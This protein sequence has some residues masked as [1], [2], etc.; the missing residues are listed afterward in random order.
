MHDKVIQQNNEYLQKDFG[1]GYK[2]QP[3]CYRKHLETFGVF[4]FFSLAFYYYFVCV[5]KNYIPVD[6]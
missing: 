1:E 6:L 2:P 3:F 5:K 4:I